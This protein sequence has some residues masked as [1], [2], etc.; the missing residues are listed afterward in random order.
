[1]I[2]QTHYIMEKKHVLAGLHTFTILKHFL[3]KLTQGGNG[4]KQT[5][6]QTSKKQ[7][8]QQQT[9]QKPPTKEKNTKNPTTHQEAQPSPASL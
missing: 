3:G 2:T 7:Q 6:K 8:Q 1:M 4:K 5:D 9:N